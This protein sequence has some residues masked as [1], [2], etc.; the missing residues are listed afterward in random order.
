MM[1]VLLLWLGMEMICGKLKKVEIFYNMKK[2][3]YKKIIFFC[4]VILF[5]NGL[6]NI[7]FFKMWEVFKKWKYF[8][9][10]DND[11]FKEWNYLMFEFVMDLI[12][13]LVNIFFGNLGIG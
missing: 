13:F 10:W 2:K 11:V 6:I 8:Y 5:N 9:I 7:W 4:G 3:I 12:C 1:D